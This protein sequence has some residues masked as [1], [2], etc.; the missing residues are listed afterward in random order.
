MEAR[1]QDVQHISHDVLAS[2]RCKLQKMFRQCAGRSR[3]ELSAPCAE[4]RARTGGKAGD[5]DFEDSSETVH[6]ELIRLND[7]TC[8]AIDQALDRIEAGTYGICQ[9]CEETIQ[10]KRLKAAP[11]A[12]LCLD[13]KNNEEEASPAQHLTRATGN[14]PMTSLRASGRV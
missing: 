2:I 3:S 13:C 1:L 8:R 7:V 4:H 5:A 6:I 10:L 12:T 11:E 9:E 14:L